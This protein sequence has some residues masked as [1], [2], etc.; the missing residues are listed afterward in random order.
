MARTKL[1][2]ASLIL[3]VAVIAGWTPSV[4]AASCGN[5]V[6][7]DGGGNDEGCDDGNTVQTDGCLNDCTVQPGW[8][9]PENVCH[10]IVCGDAIVDAPE[11]C[12]G[13]ACCSGTCTFLTSTCRASSGVCDPAEACSGSSATCP[14]DAK[15]TSVCRAAAGDCDVEEVCDGA[16]NNCPADDK[17]PSTFE[18]REVGGPCDPDGEFCTG[19]TNACPSDTFASAGTSCRAAAGACDIAETCTGSSGDCPADVMSTSTCRA[20]AGVCDE[21]EVCS[22]SDADCPADDK[23]TSVCRAAAGD[24]DV[25]EVCDGATNNCPADDKQPSTFECREDGGPCD[26]DGEFCTGSTNACPSDTFSSAGTPCRAAAGACD[27]AETCT[28]SSGN[29]PADA[30]STALCR[31]SVGV[32]DTAETCT[33]SGN[34]CPADAKSDDVCRPAVNEACDEEEVCNGS[35]D[36]C[37]DDVLAGPCLGIDADGI[38]CTEATCMP[39]GSC[40]VVENCVEICRGPGFWQTHSGYEKGANIGQEV[41]DTGG[42]IENVCGFDVDSYDDNDIGSILEALCIRVQGIQE[43]QLLRQLLTA[44]LNCQISE[45]GDCSDIFS[46][47]SDVSITTCNNL[48]AGAPLP[49][50][51]PTV[52]ECI[53]ALACFNGGGRFEEGVCSK[54]TCDDDGATLCEEDEDCDEGED[55]VRFADSCAREDICTEDLETPADTC[56][57]WHPASSPKTCRDA[58][59]NGIAFF[60]NIN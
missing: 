40:E 35:D 42:T 51:P 33:G 29:C 27:L 26:P 12:D 58:R 28:G 31:A 6:L 24:C 34:D 3:G 14:A 9:C 15:S 43:R 5:G 30:K 49:E 54:G 21:A 19:S 39:D 52:E 44:R 10:L 1:A 38:E 25:E 47:F 46:R 23:L 48:C 36:N 59:K 4:H 50:N 60:P 8:A 17:Q 7:N 13:G 41:L 11:Q 53:D 56:P 55:C 57:Q 22:G 37:P 18:C 16:A 20:A 2:L 45:G 32:C